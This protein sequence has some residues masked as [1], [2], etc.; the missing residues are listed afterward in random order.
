M[1]QKNMPNPPD[2]RVF[3]A[4]ERTLLAWQR[5][6]LA[7]MAF[8]FVIERFSLFLAA[9]QRE[10]QTPPRHHFSL[11]V[12]LMLILLGATVAAASSIAFGRFVSTLPPCDIPNARWGALGIGVNLTIAVIG[13]A[14]SAYLLLA[15][16]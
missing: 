4:A 7:L 6:S 9:V 11:V 14:L 16:L 5:S 15:A 3:F 1:P 8:G 2:P 12:G 10:A 13:V